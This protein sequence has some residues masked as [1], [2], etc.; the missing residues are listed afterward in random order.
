MSGALNVTSYM[1]DHGHAGPPTLGVET[2]PGVYDVE[3]LV[4][5]MPAFYA[6][7]FGLTLDANVKESAAI[8]LCVE[9]TSG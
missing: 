2:E 5:P 9:A 7:G 6:V 3:N 8:Y 4:F 1:P